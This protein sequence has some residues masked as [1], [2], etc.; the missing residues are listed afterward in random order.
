MRPPRTSPRRAGSAASTTCAVLAGCHERVDA[1]I[2]GKALYSGA[3]TLEEALARRRI[4]G[5]SGRGAP[6]WHPDGLAVRV[7]P[8]LDVTEGR[9]VKGVRFVELRDAGDPVELARTYDQEGADELCFLDI[10]ASSDDRD[11]MR[12][13]GG[14]WPTRCRS[15]S[16]SGAGCAPSTTRGAC[17]TPVRT[18]S[19]STPLRCSGPSCSRRRPTPVGSQS[20]VDRDRCAPRRAADDPSQGW[21]VVI[22]GGRTAD[23]HRRRRVG[24]AGAELGAG[25]IL[26]T[27]MDRD[28]TKAGSTSSCSARSPMPS[29]SR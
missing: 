14:A 6:R 23:R 15:R 2:V 22:H 11:I 17:C 24:D 5:V 28:G 3:F 1:A 26:L 20:V 8:C 13:R 9:V 25:E 27:S 21:E 16:P 19:R 12:R 18:R 10:T 29:R 4:T 7:I